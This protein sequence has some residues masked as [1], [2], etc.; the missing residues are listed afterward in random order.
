[1]DLGADGLQTFRYITLPTLA[2]ALFAG[3]LLAFALS[4]DEVI[5]TVF[6]SGQQATLPIWI[7]DQLTRPRQ[8]P[9]TNVAA[10]FVIALTV[11]PILLANWLTRRLES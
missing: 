6:T 8:R 10:V 4:F 1:M 5:V 7:L 11:G 2:T 3:G 9:V